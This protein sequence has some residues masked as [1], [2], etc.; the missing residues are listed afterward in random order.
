[1]RRA[2]FT[3]LEV[4]IALAILAMALFVLVDAQA[5]AV[6][7]T[8]DAEKT[9][10]GSYLAQH[11]MT[12]ATLRLEKEGFK[13]ADVNDEGDFEDFGEDD[14]LGGMDGASVGEEMEFG[15][16]F[17]GYQ[18]AYSIRQV[19]ISLGD[20][21][22]AQETLQSAGFGPSADQADAA[23]NQGA[24]GMDLADAG[25]QPDMISEMLSPFIREVRVVVWW[26]AE[27]KSDAP[28]EDCVELVTHV[29]NPSGDIFDA[30]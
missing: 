28:C 20:V 7:V 22:G 25:I 26:G 3:L 12:E 30:P 17:D 9:L 14:G 2:G 21:A 5:S 4:V 24:A 13:T 15:D 1:M 29:I 6:L 23:G 19:D 8:L 11:K 16:G 10:V 18:W 27:P